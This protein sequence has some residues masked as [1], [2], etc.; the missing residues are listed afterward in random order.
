MLSTILVLGA[1]DVFLLFTVELLL[2]ETAFL[3]DVLALFLPEIAS[4]EPLLEERP[5]RPAIEDAPLLAV[6]LCR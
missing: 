3:V 1:F 5:D 2:P 4:R 6:A